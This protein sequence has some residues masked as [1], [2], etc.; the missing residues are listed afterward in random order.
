MNLKKRLSTI[1]I[2]LA[3]L[4]TPAIAYTQNTLLLQAEEPKAVS[5]SAPADKTTQATLVVRETPFE[6][7][8]WPQPIYRQYLKDLMT[9]E[10]AES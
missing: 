6:M 2:I 1:S 9:A 3:A 7:A 8:D 4:A 5:V 10:G